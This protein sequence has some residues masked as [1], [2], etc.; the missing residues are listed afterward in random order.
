MFISDRSIVVCFHIPF[1]NMNQKKE[2][3]PGKSLL[4]LQTPRLII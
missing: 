4:V 2:K 3:T 1:C